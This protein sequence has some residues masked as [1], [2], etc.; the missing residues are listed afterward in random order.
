MLEESG[1]NMPASHACLWQSGERGAFGGLLIGRLAENIIAPMRQR[2]SLPYWNEV[3]LKACERA[4]APVGLLISKP[5]HHSRV[6]LY[7][8]RA[9]IADAALPCPALLKP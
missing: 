6:I 4:P 1:H 2:G 3:T 9:I 8:P 5:A 7:A